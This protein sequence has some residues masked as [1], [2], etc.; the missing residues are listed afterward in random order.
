VSNRA[1]P[2]SFK[3]FYLALFRSAIAGGYTVMDSFL[4]LIAVIL[5]LVTLLNR[6][7][8]HELEANWNGLSRWWSITPIACVLVYRGMKAN[9]AHFESLVKQVDDLSEQIKAHIQIEGS[10]QPHLWDDRRVEGYYFEVFNTSF[11]RTIEEVEVTLNDINPNPLGWRPPIHLH[12]K[13]TDYKDT[14]TFSL[15]PRQSHMIDL[16]ASAVGSAYI[17]LWEVELNGQPVTIPADK[18]VVKVSVG[19][20]HVPPNSAMFSVWKDGDGHLVCERV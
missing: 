15:N 16:V 18:Y 20:K 14:K 7:L 4:T 9:Y 19:G 11:A 1:I 6:E 12:A 3:G 5:F 13:H 10:P 17:Y 2:R 8:A